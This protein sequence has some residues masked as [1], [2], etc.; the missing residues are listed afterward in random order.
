MP[1]KFENL[2]VWQRSIDIS[3]KVSKIVKSFPKDEI[4]VLAAQLK[5]SADSV[6]LNIAEG[7]TSQSNAEFNRFLGYALRSA[8]E[9]VG[10]LFLARKRELIKEED[11]YDLYH[12]T[13]ITVK[14]IQSL[15][16][17]VK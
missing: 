8:I 2:E 17:S 1:F 4:F 16:K 12:E 14:M 13:E 6:S 7:S 10:G 5:R 11:F 9:L 15:R 3:Y